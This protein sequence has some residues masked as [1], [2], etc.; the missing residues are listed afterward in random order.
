L[1]CCPPT[2]GYDD[3]DDEDGLPPPPPGPP[4]MGDD[5]RNNLDDLEWTHGNRSK[6][7]EALD[8]VKE[9]VGSIKMFSANEDEEKE[10]LVSGLSSLIFLS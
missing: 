1:C 3:D 8:K 10:G 6:T 9:F 7:E 4:H 2:Q 5:K